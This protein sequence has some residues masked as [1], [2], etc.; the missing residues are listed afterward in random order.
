MTA[1]LEFGKFSI[2]WDGSRNWVLSE[3][4]KATT[5]GKSKDGTVLPVGRDIVSQLGFYGTLEDAICS[6]LERHI[7]NSEAKSAVAI[8]QEIRMARDAIVGRLG[9]AEAKAEVRKAVRRAE[10]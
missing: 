2:D 8:V 9:L 1:H 7:N 4:N 10:K 6:V 5:E 3:T